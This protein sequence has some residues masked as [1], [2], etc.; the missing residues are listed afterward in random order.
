MSCSVSRALSRINDKL[1]KG[2]GDLGRQIGILV[3]HSHDP[4]ASDSLKRLQMRTALTQAENT[5]SEF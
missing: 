2:W 5:D 1:P 4:A 3:T